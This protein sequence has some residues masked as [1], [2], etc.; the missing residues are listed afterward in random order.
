MFRF[1][2]FILGIAAGFALALAVLPIPGKTFFNRMSK[3]PPSAKD[4]IDNSI[5]L[6]ISF[7]RV[8][9]TAGKEF[10]HRFSAVMDKTK[11]KIDELNV[12]YSDELDKFKAKRS[13]QATKEEAKV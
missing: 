4:L 3:L 7:F 6:G 13:I 12:K 2:S 5:S 10:N 1:I 11:V 8:A 9:F